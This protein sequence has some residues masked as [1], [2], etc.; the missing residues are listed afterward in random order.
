[1]ADFRDLESRGVPE[2]LWPDDA[3]QQKYTKDY[4]LSL[5]GGKKNKILTNATVPAKKDA[6]KKP[7][8]GIKVPVRIEIE[9]RFMLDH[10]RHDEIM[11]ELCSHTGGSSDNQP[12]PGFLV[13]TIRQFYGEESRYRHSGATIDHDQRIVVAETFVSEKKKTIHM[14]APYSVNTEDEAYVSEEEFQ[15]GW[16]TSTKRLQKVRFQVPSVHSGHR[17]VVDFFYTHRPSNVSEA[18]ETVIYAVSAEDEVII[19]GTAQNISLAFILPI[20]LQKYI[21]CTV[22]NRDPTMKCFRSASMVDDV[23]VI[24]KFEAAISQWYECK[25][26]S[27]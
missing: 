7:K 21:I 9:Q 22:D 26:Q 5:A 10:R 12:K 16:L 1:M 23:D 15:A 3:F 6:G 20:Y 14:N 11:A 2:H 4:M 8:K 27:A 24:N 25:E 13:H 17:T 19:D 18:V